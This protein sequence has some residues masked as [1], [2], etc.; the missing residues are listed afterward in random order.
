MPNKRK[1]HFEPGNID[2]VV[3]E[4]TNLLDAA[5]RAGLR[6]VASCGGAGTCGTCKVLIK[7]GQ[8]KSTQSGKISPEEY[9]LGFRLACQSKILSDLVVHIP[10]ES[11]LDDQ[12]HKES[13]VNKPQQP[14]VRGWKFNPPLKKYYLDM[15]QPTI[16]DNISDLSRVLRSLKQSYQLDNITVDFSIINKLSRVL[17]AGKWKATATILATELES[18]SIYKNQL[19][20]INIESGDTTKKSY[21][22]AFDIGTTTVKGQ[23]L[24]IGKGTVISEEIKHNG[25]AVYGSDVVSRIA[26]CQKPQGLEKL[27]KAVT[28]T[29][30]EI[31]SGLLNKGNINNHDISHFVVAG[32]TTMSQIFL[33]VDPK[34]IRLSPYTPTMT[35][36]PSVKVNS[37]GID[38]EE[39]VYLY[40]LPSVSSYVGGDIVAGA[41]AAGIHQTKKL[42][43]YID[44]GTNG[45]IVIGNSSWMVTAACSAGP[46]FEGGEIKHGMIATSG[47][48]EYFDINPLTLEPTIGTIDKQKPKGICGSGLINIVA[49]LLETGVISQNGKFHTEPG[50]PRIR[51]GNDG[52]EYVLVWASET[53]IGKDIVITETDIDNLIRAKAAMYAGCQTLVKSVGLTCG[54]IEQ[55]IIA[56]AFGN[57][58]NIEKAITIGLLPDLPRE[59][60]IFIGNGSLMGARLAAFS[61]GIMKDIRK[62]AKIMTNFEFSENTEFMNNYIAALFLPHTNASEFTTINNRIIKKTQYIT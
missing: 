17:R 7:K 51:K 36:V 42:T 13:A 33:G 50:S 9:K 24:D 14:L 21:C 53:Q 4:G 19:N 34:Y 12:K 23:L 60:F 58:M 37:M 20:L 59:R 27:R 25:Q 56:G 31:I 32:N 54:D 26:Y 11:L 22:L 1:I 55:V 6:L 38:L 44:I 8:V 30:N 57:Y 29:I 18:T 46:A 35:Y 52:Y 39:H 43:F 62:T 40:V 48:I 3:D 2:V 15:P 49:G 16:T 45:E 10:V 41:V 61:T 28:E 5:I 47:A